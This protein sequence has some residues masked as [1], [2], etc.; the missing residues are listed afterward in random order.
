MCTEESMEGVQIRC[1]QACYWHCHRQAGYRVYGLI[2]TWAEFFECHANTIVGTTPEYGALWQHR[3][4][5]NFVP[6]ISGW[7]WTYSLYICTE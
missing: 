2:T 6:A 5:I 1:Q 3:D 4:R 7:P